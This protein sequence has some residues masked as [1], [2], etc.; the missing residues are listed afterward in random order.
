MSRLTAIVTLLVLPIWA[1]AAD[2]IPNVE[3]TITSI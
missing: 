2:P 1:A 3:A